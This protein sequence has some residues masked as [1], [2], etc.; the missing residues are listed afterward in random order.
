MWLSL[1]QWPAM[2]VTVVAAWLVSSGR[3]F[4]RNWGFW[5][6]LLSNILWIVWAVGDRA[7][8][9][10]VLQICLAVM[11]IRGVRTN[12]TSAAP[13]RSIM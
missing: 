10:I 2:V 3:K 7:Y 6:F 11:N 13:A 9:M 4:K 12:D 8:A 5:I 1:V